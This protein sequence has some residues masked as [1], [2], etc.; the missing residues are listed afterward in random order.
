MLMIFSCLFTNTHIHAYIQTNT[1]TQVERARRALEKA[2]KRDLIHNAYTYIHTYIHTHTHKQAEGEK[3]RRALEKA[4]AHGLIQCIHTHTYI[5]IH[6]QAEVEKARRALEKAEARGLLP[7]T[8]EPPPTQKQAF[9]Q[10]YH[11]EK[12]HGPDQ[13]MRGRGDAH[14]QGQENVSMHV[15]GHDGDVHGVKNSRLSARG[16]GDADQQ[17]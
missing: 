17:V 6:A 10:G 14:Y 5:H 1:Q 13:R 7:D 12:E 8:H 4:E 15:H 2:E 3:E 9:Q 16:W 11:T